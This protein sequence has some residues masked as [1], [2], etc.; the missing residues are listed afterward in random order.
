MHICCTQVTV[1]LQ[2]ALLRLLNEI[3]AA[4]FGSLLFAAAAAA[5]DEGG[6]AGVVCGFLMC[7]LF[8]C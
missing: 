8:F 2:N 6:D 7:N 5:D 1:C 4:D 3:C